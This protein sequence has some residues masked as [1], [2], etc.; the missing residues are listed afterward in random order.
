MEWK[1]HHSSDARSQVS[2]CCHHCGKL[3]CNETKRVEKQDMD[4]G[5]GVTEEDLKE[6][7]GFVVP[8][9][10]FPLNFKERPDGVLGASLAVHCRD[11][12][13]KFHPEMIKKRSGRFAKIFGG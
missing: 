9:P 13:E 2:A 1:C 3:I 11:C 8:D 6:K 12:L 4:K 5:A 7:C 10:E